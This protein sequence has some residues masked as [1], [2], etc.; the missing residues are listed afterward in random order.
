VTSARTAQPARARAAAA[1][2]RSKARS[3]ARPTL[4]TFPADAAASPA[5]RYGQLSAL[6][7]RTELGRRGIG[8][9]RAEPAPGVL[10]PVRLTGPLAGVTWRTDH[11]ESE[12]RRTPYE[13]FDC[14]L[15]L[16]LDDFSRLLGAHDVDEVR[17]FSGWRPP[18]KR[19]PSGKPG[20]R[21][22]GGLAVDVRLLHRRSASS[23]VVLDHWAGSVGQTTCG[24]SASAP[25]SDAAET[26]ELRSIVCEAADQRLFNS[27][28]TP[29]HDAAHANHLHL[30]IA[31]DVRWFI[32]D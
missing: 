20:R 26:R 8:F 31:P 14:R 27:I 13:V 5:V 23:L 10:A 29:H 16:A 22:P 18:G 21:H 17:V 2:A 12:R 28:L 30:E 7:C 32:V 1:R 9:R 6:D 11:A 24:P 4:A 19:W 25:G 3:R 15:V